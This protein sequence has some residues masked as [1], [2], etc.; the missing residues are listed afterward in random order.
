[1]DEPVIELGEVAG[2]RPSD[3][4][5]RAG[6]RRWPSARV[7]AAL[8]A[9]AFGLGLVAG[10]AA[11]H[12]RELEQRRA[13]VRQEP[14]ILLWPGT[15]GASRSDGR[16]V[17]FDAQVTAVNNGTAAIE[18]GNLR[19]Q[20]VGFS[21][22]SSPRLWRIQAGRLWTFNVTVTW[23]CTGRFP[24][25]VLPVGV[26]V[27]HAGGRVEQVSSP[28]VLRDSGWPEYGAEFCGRFG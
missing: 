18:I 3:G 10:A 23:D 27:E 25:E 13:E 15:V 7:P 28:M 20:Q 24:Y 8:L 17:T 26:S 16:L 2:Q 14:V 19:A 4:G 12:L 22:D 1:M 21:M 6:W 9:A 5:R 11:Y